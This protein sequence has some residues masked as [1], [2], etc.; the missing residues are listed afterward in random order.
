MTDSSS[1]V[2]VQQSGPQWSA[3]RV[4]VAGLMLLFG[5]AFL[6]FAMSSSNAANKD[7]VMY[8]AAGKQLVHH[9]NP[10]NDAQIFRLERDAGSKLDRPYFMRNSPIALL[11]AVPF[12]FMREWP[13]ALLWSVLLVA[14]VMISIRMIWQI[15]GRPEGRLHLVGYIFPPVLS[16]MT[17]GQIGILLLLGFTTFLYFHRTREFVAGLALVLCSLK[18]HLFIPFSLILLIWC[19]QKRAFRILAGFAAGLGICIL[20]VSILDPSVWSQY[21]QMMNAEDVLQQPLPTVSLLLRVAVNQNAVWIQFVP[22]VTASL[23]ALWYFRRSEWNWAHQGLLLLT[24]SVM[25]APYAWFTDESVVLPAI[26]AAVYRLE[27]KRTSLVPFLL[28]AG[29]ALCEVMLGKGVGTFW[30]VWT[31][32]AWVGFVVYAARVRRNAA[33]SEG[34]AV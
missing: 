2:S 34:V 13:A 31:A 28:V 29:P 17:L 15:Q 22:A 4:I 6:A 8:W 27:Q 18:P 30:Y 9:A 19:I 11:L 12:G 25:V 5:V 7:F 20:L 10:Y 26:L 14:S 1:E 21:A 3:V 33:I 16:C 32:P 23:W 24:V